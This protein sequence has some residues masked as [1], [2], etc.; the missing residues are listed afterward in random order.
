MYKIVII[1]LAIEDIRESALW[2]EARLKGLGKRFTSE[3]RERIRSIRQN[4]RI[5][6]VRYE[7]VRAVVLIAYPFMIHYILDESKRTVIIIGVLHT[8]RNPE[9]WKTR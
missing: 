7:N 3:V 9:Y 2:Y 8:S 5:A 4:P 1:P 6:N